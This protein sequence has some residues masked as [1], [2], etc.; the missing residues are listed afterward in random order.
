MGFVRKHMKQMEHHMRQKGHH[1]GC[2]CP[3]GGGHQEC[4]KKMFMAMVFFGMM[5]IV[6][7]F[8]VG[9]LHLMLHAKETFHG[10]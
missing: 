4:K 8:I 3:M 10:H 9:I 7:L 1:G 2:G 6:N 5:A